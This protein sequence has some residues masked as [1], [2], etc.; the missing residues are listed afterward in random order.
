MNQNSKLRIQESII[1][2]DEPE[3]HLHPESEFKI[4]QKISDLIKDK[5][6]LWI[7][8]HSISILSSLSYDEIF[9]IKSG[10]VFPPSRITP[11]NSFVE[12]MGL[13]DHIEKLTQFITNISTWTFLNF[14]G[15]CFADPDVIRCAQDNDPEFELFK[16][17]IKEREGHSILLDFGAGQGRIYK[18]FIKDEELVNKIQYSALEP[19]ESNAAELKA[20]N[21]PTYLDYNELPEKIFDIVLL[22][23]V[24]HEIDISK[25]EVTLNRISNSLNDNGFLIIIED[26]KLP[27]GEKIEGAGFVI[28]DIE[29]LAKLFSIN[30][31][32][33]Q[34]LINDERY[35]DRILCTVIPKTNLE[36]VTNTTISDSLQKLR[37]NI[38]ERLKKLRGIPVTTENKLTL[39][40]ESAYCSQLYI[41]CLFAS[42][43]L[44]GD[45]ET[46]E[47]T[48]DESF[49]PLS[50][51][52]QK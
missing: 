20:L 8:T 10:K 17:S 26:Q 29:S 46:L 5:G 1:I 18:E 3:L 4:I 7:A 48:K 11:G 24:L 38:F 34:L 16:K 51:V 15:Q 22:C 2:I 14:M 30:S 35:K 28:M 32:P 19:D 25:W 13:E 6:Q 52:F 47:K 50:V 42:Q 49:S 44:S 21:I 41:N 40:R 36:K 31:A 39:G 43:I 12:L 45:N 33:T 9:M 23:N 37:E 27:K